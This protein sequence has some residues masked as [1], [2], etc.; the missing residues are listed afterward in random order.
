MDLEVP[1][2]DCITPDTPL[3]EVSRELD[4]LP[5]HPIEQMSWPSYSYK[6]TVRFSIA[7]TET[8]IVLKYFVQENSIRISCH[9]NN[10]PVYQDS[11]VEFF[12]SF[13]GEE[14]YYNLE[15][16][17]IGTCLAAF[18]RRK[19][20]RQLLQPELISA[21]RR[22]SKIESLTDDPVKKVS[23]QL[24]LDIPLNVFAFHKIGSLKNRRCKVNFYK[25]GDELPEPHFLS[26]KEV[27][28]QLPDFHTPES[29]GLVQFV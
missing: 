19:A 7:Y 23:W 16:N 27:H 18:G 24:T 9:A 1:F 13:D 2:F 28:T 3:S 12:I 29:F 8:S 4:Q 20:G 21:I 15:F 26:W 11:C 5:R 22:M 25:C 6:P 10:S 17:S 14:D